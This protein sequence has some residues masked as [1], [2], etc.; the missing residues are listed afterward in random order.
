MGGL[1]YVVILNWNGRD[2][3]RD[4]LRAALQQTYEPY[5]VLVVDNGSP[6]RSGEIVAQE[7]PEATLVPLAENLHFAKGT[8]VGI[9][10]A[11][12]DPTCEY[13]VTLNNDTR[14][15]PDW[16]AALVRTAEDGIGMVASKLLM[17]DRPRVL[18]STGISIGL[19]GSGLDRGWNE[20]DA[21]QYDGSGDVFGPSAGAALYGRRMLESIGLFDEEF[22]AYYEDL[23]LAWRARLSGWRA[24]YA[25]DAVVFHKVSASHRRGSSL[26]TYLCERNRI[27]NLVQNY[28]WR[29]AALGLPWNSART[30]AGPVPWTDDRD[31]SLD[32]FQ[33]PLWETARAMAQARLD[34]YAGLRRA[35]WKRRRRAATSCVDAGTV[36]E[37]LRKYHVSLRASV[38]A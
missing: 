16:L 38:L 18:N 25:P 3:I 26:K 23:D 19:D 37:W 34:A 32:R 30:L 12:R 2:F 10:E 29:Y 15:G 27:W 7:F 9:R 1:A 13:I 6:D 14:A 31:A 11:L 33:S 35:L 36:G 21:G 28:P 22:V 17:M 8:N 4:C 5:R 24:Q 20:A